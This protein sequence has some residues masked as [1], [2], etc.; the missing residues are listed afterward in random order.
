MVLDFSADVRDLRAAI[1]RERQW[2][3]SALRAAEAE[4]KKTSPQ[5]LALEQVSLRVAALT[6]VLEVEGD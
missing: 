1:R 2:C 4:L 3:L 6:E 5:S